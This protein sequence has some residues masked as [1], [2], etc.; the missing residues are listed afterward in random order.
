MSVFA[1]LLKTPEPIYNA[2][3]SAGLR[4]LLSEP[5]SDA[6]KRLGAHG[7]RGLWR[8]VERPESC[9]RTTSPRGVIIS[10]LSGNRPPRDGES[11]LPPARPRQKLARS[12]VNFSL[13]RAARRRLGG[14]GVPAGRERS[15]AEL[16]RGGAGRG[17]G[18]GWDPKGVRAERSGREQISGEVPLDRLRSASQV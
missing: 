10:A 17:Q 7:R 13:G 18:T 2:N 14:A 9:R 4:S 3:F 16:D 8:G 12:Q 15:G 11:R 5:P 1:N 6:E